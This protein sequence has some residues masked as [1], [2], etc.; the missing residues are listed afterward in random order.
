MKTIIL[1]LLLSVVA[2][3]AHA[4][5]VAYRVEHTD[6]FSYIVELSDTKSELCGPFKARVLMSIA[7][8]G[9]Q[10][11]EPFADGCWHVDQY[12]EEVIS[13]L[14]LIDDGRFLELRNPF[15]LYTFTG[16]K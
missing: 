13:E 7:M 1:S 11:A 9:S 6:D 2:T 8:N 5:R 4:E 15:L 16:Q 3:A 10:H 12:S 14:W